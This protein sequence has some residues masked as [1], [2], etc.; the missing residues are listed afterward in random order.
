MRIINDIIIFYFGISLF[1]NSILFIP[2]IIKILKEKKTDEFS[3]TTFVGFCLTQLAS[4][5]YG[6]IQHDWLLMWGYILALITCG[7][8]TV[9]IFVYR[10]N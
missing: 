6:Y 2:Q 8:V 1:A 7:T 10:N 4:I 9:L 3:I 5:L